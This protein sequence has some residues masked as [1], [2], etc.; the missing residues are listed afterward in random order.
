MRN[1]LNLNNPADYAESVA[2]T[3]ADMHGQQY[4]AFYAGRD[5]AGE[6]WRVCP[7]PDS[8]REPRTAH[9]ARFTVAPMFDRYRH[10]E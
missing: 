5:T 8:P 6:V 3:L 9:C 7:A 10:F 2:R 4:L 1:R